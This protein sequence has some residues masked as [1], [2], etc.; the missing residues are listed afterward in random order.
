MTT[1]APDMEKV[2]AFAQQ[3]GAVLAGGATTAMMVVGDRAGLYAAMAAGGPLT[4][5]QLAREA[6]AAEP[7]VREWLSQQA[8]VG[9]VTFDP[10]DGTFTLPPEHAA[11]LA[12]DDSPA[13]MIGAAPLISGMH[14]R[15]DQLVE[16]FRSGA[17][18]PWADQDPATFESTERF[19][20]V[21]YRNSLVSEWIPALDGV[22]EKLEAGATVVDVGCG[23]G[24][25]LLLMAEAYP[26]SQ[27]VG[28]D[29]HRPSVETATKR[30]AEAGVS[31]RVRFEVN[32]CQGYPDTGVDVV[33]F[34]DA[35]HDLGDPV[36]A[37]SHARRSLAPDGTLVLVE[38]LAA[39]DLATTLATAP[40]AALGF[41]A[42]T[43]LCTPNSLSQPV[44]LALGA[45]AGEARLRDALTEAGYSS[46]RRAA[47]NDFNM[48][49]EAKP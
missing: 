35:F 12:S 19:F 9:F 43:F 28:Y 16:V 37:A 33:T 14:R 38:P 25:P 41:A 20:R 45:Q 29:V 32:S 3:V 42:S 15:T 40:M 4:P 24:A 30:A 48:V 31:N 5:A 49:V 23:H 11:V 7:Y 8:A 13:A 21:G 6:G 27:F 26:N 47:E 44:G 17:G 1:A 2:G 34:F 18:I 22:H 39:D 36:G 46:V 10:I